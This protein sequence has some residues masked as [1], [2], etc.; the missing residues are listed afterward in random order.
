[1]LALAPREGGSLPACA[2]LR[3]LIKSRHSHLDIG[4]SHTRKAPGRLVLQAAQLQLRWQ[5]LTRKQVNLQP[6]LKHR[7]VKIRSQHCHVGSTTED[8]QN[9][10][11]PKRSSRCRIG[12]SQWRA[13]KGELLNCLRMQ[14]DPSPHD[15]CAVIPPMP[16]PNQR[17]PFWKTGHHSHVAVEVKH[18]GIHQSRLLQVRT[19]LRAAGSSE[20]SGCES[21][22]LCVNEAESEREREGRRE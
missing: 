8:T 11:D 6:D 16:P 1:M 10:A 19:L 4:K 12:S 20:E 21:V 9:Q 13:Q 14:G 18:R 7:P 3:H 15:P 2:C 22:R 5:S 17:S